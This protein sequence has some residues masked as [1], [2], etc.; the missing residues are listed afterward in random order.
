MISSGFMMSTCPIQIG[1]RYKIKTGGGKLSFIGQSFRYFVCS[2]QPEALGRSSIAEKSFKDKRYLHLEGKQNK[3]Y[4]NPSFRSN[5]PVYTSVHTAHEVHS[6]RL[7][8]F[9]LPSKIPYNTLNRPYY[10]NNRLFWSSSDNSSDNSKKKEV[11]MEAD[12]EKDIQE[13]KTQKSLFTK[14][15][16]SFES[17]T[18]IHKSVILLGGS[19]I[20]GLSYLVYDVVFGFMTMKPLDMGLYGLYTG[21][22][23]A[24]AGVGI[25]NYLLYN[26]AISPEVAY[27]KSMNFIFYNKKAHGLIGGG[28]IRNAIMS[29]KVYKQTGKYITL[30]GYMPVYDPITVHMMYVV[31]GSQTNKPFLV[32]CSIQK[33]NFKTE[34]TY[35]G[36]QKVYTDDR[37][38]DT[39]PQ[40]LGDL[41]VITGTPTEVCLQLANGSSFNLD[42]KKA[43][44]ND[45][46]PM[47]QINTE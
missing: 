23:S 18:T 31:K 14:I 19:A 24:G 20:F 43:I 15:A 12:S 21:V 37:C 40:W 17:N 41:E 29:M 34:V 35:L 38:L 36:L 39:R 22:L 9:S 28:Y 46:I 5:R 8:L 45:K 26:F 44:V 11:E 33:I 6:P 32:T 2:L 30:D 27:Q 3:K 13:D 1:S 16:D 25:A 47:P 10:Q 42:Y 7:G 4:L